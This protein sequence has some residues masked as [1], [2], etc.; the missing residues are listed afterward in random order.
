MQNVHSQSLNRKNKELVLSAV[1][2]KHKHKFK[3]QFKGDCQICGKKGHKA[4]EC[5]DSERNKD[6]RPAN[7]KPTTIPSKPTEPPKG[8]KKET[9]PLLLL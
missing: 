9:S 1:Q 3:K 8:A 6:K 4:S 7:Y 5:W 2:G